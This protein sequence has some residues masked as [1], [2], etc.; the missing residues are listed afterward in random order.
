VIFVQ[1]S[2]APAPINATWIS[3][4]KDL[5]ERRTNAASCLTDDQKDI[6]VFG[7]VS[8]NFQMLNSVLL[9]NIEKDEWIPLQATPS[10]EP[11]KKMQL[12]CLSNR[13]VFLFGGTTSSGKYQ[14]KSFILDIN[15][16]TWTEIQLKTD[17]IP[18]ARIS[19]ALHLWKENELILYGGQGPTGWYSDSWIFRLDTNE[20][21]EHRTNGENPGKR[22]SFASVVLK[23]KLFLFG[24]LEFHGSEGYLGDLYRL[25]GSTWTKLN[26]AG[27]PPERRAVASAIAIERDESF[28]IFGG[29]NYAG[30]TK[31]DVRRYDV[32][33]DW[34][35]EVYP[36]GIIAPKRSAHI[37]AFAADIMYVFGGI[38]DGLGIPSKEWIK[39]DSPR[40]KLFFP[41][42]KHNSTLIDEIKDL[43]V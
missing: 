30:F 31:D 24:G 43:V 19:F 8:E 22:S 16:K 15:K 11:M 29:Y 27:Y 39:K 20:W 26:S 23:G 40:L 12:V 35:D 41:S 21:I 7:G 33:K 9:Y 42:S 6:V 2:V 28:L 4:A 5:P 34:W 18:N 38:Y 25:E 3:N 37:S 1:N 14:S 10:V 17:K 36:S 32:E 13:R